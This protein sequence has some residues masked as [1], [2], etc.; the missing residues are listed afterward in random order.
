[1]GERTSGLEPQPSSSTVTQ[2]PSSNSVVTLQAAT[3]GRMGLAIFNDSTSVLYVKQG[4]GASSTNYTVKTMVL[5]GR[6]RP[7]STSMVSE[8]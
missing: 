4:S 5:S 3:T 1:M 6:L 8:F 2:V 7:Y